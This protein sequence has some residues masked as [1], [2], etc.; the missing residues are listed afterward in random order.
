MTTQTIHIT[1]NFSS[2]GTRSVDERKR[3]TLGDILGD[4]ERLQIFQNAQGEILLKPVVEIPA[5][6]AWLFNNKK[7]LAAVKRGLQQAAEGKISK[8]D[9]KSL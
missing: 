4:S 1:S 6:E 3:V 9:L 2:M 5:S 8:L 7:A